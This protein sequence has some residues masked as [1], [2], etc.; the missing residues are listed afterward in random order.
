MSGRT[1]GVELGNITPRE[2]ESITAIK[3]MGN[4]FKKM[5]TAMGT[6]STNVGWGL[7]CSS[8]CPPQ[9]SKTP[10][11]NYYNYLS[12]L[13]YWLAAMCNRSTS[14][15]VSKISFEATVPAVASCG[16]SHQIIPNI[17]TIY[18]GW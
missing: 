1:T 14:A 3:E 6:L 8:Y 5:H 2:M 9:W 11:L 12:P 16:H 18:K 17:G 15:P 4:I 13:K 7:M 10:L